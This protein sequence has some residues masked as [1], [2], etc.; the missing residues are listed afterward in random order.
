MLY[1]YHTHTAF[2]DDSDS[3]LDAQIQSALKK[4]LQDMA[5]TDHYDPG[6]PDPEFPFILDFE[7]YFPAL[8]EAQARCAG[9]L[10]LAV[11]M[12]IGLMEGHLEEARQA[13]RQYPLDFVIGS[14]HCMRK[15]DLYSYDFSQGDQQATIE[16]N[17]LFIYETLK[18]YK[19]YDVVGHFTLV[20]RYVGKR[21]PYSDTT[22]DL[23]RESLKVVID[24]G[25]GLEIN[26]SNFKYNTPDLP[27]PRPEV[28]KLYRELGGEILTIGSDSHDPD[29]LGEYTDW[30]QELATS[31]GFRY[32][33]TFK[34]R[35][36]FFHAFK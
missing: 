14:F 7:N 11:G 12:E 13:I 26:T 35:K 32:Y 20:D 31:L 1:D 30:A 28:L 2:S 23:I 18:A 4:G 16:D 36:P 17:Y 5:I 29:R 21:L 15:T 6:Y 33:C 25:K 27:L 19:D 8:Q 24:D 34:E 3:P 22:M 9:S 10:N